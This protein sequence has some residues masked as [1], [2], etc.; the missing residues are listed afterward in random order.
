VDQH[1][2]AWEFLVYRYK[3]ALRSEMSSCG[4]W[5]REAR[6]MA[7]HGESEGLSVKGLT[8]TDGSK[9]KGRTSLEGRSLYA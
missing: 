2:W 6:K 9:A 1:L 7:F 3:T 8:A 5:T 4:G